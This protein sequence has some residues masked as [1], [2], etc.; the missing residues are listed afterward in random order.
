[1]YSTVYQGLDHP[2]IAFDRTC[3]K[4]PAS[5]GAAVPSAGPDN[6][7]QVKLI[8]MSDYPGHYEV[9]LGWPQ[10]PNS[11]A[12]AGKKASKLEKPPNSGQLIRDLLQELFSLDS[13]ND[14]WFTNAIKCDPNHGKDSIVVSDRVI[15]SCNKAWTSNELEL[16]DKFVPTVPILAAGAK[17]LKCLQFL[18]GTGCASG[19]I[20]SNLRH[21]GLVVGTHPL[22]CCHNPATYAKSVSF[23][24]DS[25]KVSRTGKFEIASVYRSD[26]V[27][28]APMALFKDDLLLLKDY[29]I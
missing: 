27:I 25:V 23:F 5:C 28:P 29:L 19:T 20:S 6:L 16:L 9:E 2:N 22:V 7:A 26:S 17:A 1:M 10:V 3:D 24:E 21:T 8:V 14:V 18:Y 4:C 12:Q 11:V 13:Y 15:K